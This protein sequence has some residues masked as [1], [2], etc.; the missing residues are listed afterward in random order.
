MIGADVLEIVVAKGADNPVSKRAGELIVATSLCLADP[1]A[2]AG[3]A[4]SIDESSG[5]GINLRGIGAVHAVAAATCNVT[6]GPAWGCHHRSGRLR[7]SARAHV[8]CHGRSG[9]CR[10]GGESESKFFHLRSLSIQR[11][12]PIAR[13]NAKVE[14]L[15]LR[16]P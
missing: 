1:T 14:N 9:E 16:S 2:A 10:E 11:P 4:L 6:S 13:H 5:D 3:R 8:G 15:N 7:I 12:A